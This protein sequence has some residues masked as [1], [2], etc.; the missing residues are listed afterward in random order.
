MVSYRIEGSPA[1]SVLIVSLSPGESV[2]VEPGSYMMHKGDVEIK[3][4]SR[5]FLKGL[6]RSLFGGESFFMNT[7]TAKS[8]AEVWIAPSTPGDI[9]AVELDGGSLVI[10]DG[11]YL[12]HIG[13]I[14][15][16]TAWKGLKG[17]LAE[18]ELI[19][20]KASG[21]GTVF[22]NSYGAIRMIELGEGE[23]VTVDNMHF[24]ALDSSVSWKVKK[25]GGLKSAIF[26]GEGLVV[27]ARG[28]GRV[29]VQTRN[30]PLFA[31]IIRRFLPSK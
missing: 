3:T 23:K 11:S 17:L 24:V 30:L 7:I 2:V 21:R 28:P 10:Q 1:Y 19:W 5:G 31:R 6:A 18:G 12:A 15:V 25:W 9:A 4:S 13:N 27:E 22:I 14:E 26:G 8:S 16:S 29:W 20:T